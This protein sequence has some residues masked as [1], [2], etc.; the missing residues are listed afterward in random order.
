M[1]DRLLARYGYFKRDWQRPNGH[2]DIDAIARASRWQAF[3]N[4]PGGVADLIAGIRKSYFEKVGNLKPGDTDALQ[5]LATA[6]R[7]CRELDAA[8]C[9][10]IDTG[11]LEQEARKHTDQIEGLPRSQRRRL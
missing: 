1:I 7:I 10:V 2:A 6:D 8:I 4:E 11:K 9:A 3:Y 5:A